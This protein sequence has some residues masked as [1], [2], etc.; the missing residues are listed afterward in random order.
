MDNGVGKDTLMMDFGKAYS[1]TRPVQ[2]HS[3]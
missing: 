3:L 2:D 1:L